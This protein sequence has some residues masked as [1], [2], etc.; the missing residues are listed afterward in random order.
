MLEK[1]FLIKEAFFN[2]SLNKLK[3]F[4][5]IIKGFVKKS[6]RKIGKSSFQFES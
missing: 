4:I 6:E 3:Y 2:E 1:I 5:G